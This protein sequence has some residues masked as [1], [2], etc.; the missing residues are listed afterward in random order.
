MRPI[1]VSGFPEN[2]QPKRPGDNSTMLDLHRDGRHKSDTALLIERIR[3]AENLI[4]AVIVHDHPNL[5]ELSKVQLSEA[6]STLVYA[7]TALEEK[8]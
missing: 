3:Y 7:R 5:S 6:E 1:I 8:S 4:R 2:Y